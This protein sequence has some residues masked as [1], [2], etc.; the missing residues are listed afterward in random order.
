M[1]T[2]NLISVDFTDEIFQQASNK[3][4]ELSD[5]LPFLLSLTDDQRQGGLKLGD[6]S[7]GFLEKTKDFST[8]NPE[9]IPKYAD[10]AEMLRDATVSSKGLTLARKLNV[11]RLKLEDTATIAGIEAFSA[12][13]M[14]YHAVK[15]AAKQG[16]P[17]AQAIYDDLKKRFPGYNTGNNDESKPTA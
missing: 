17:G 4:D 10:M 3:I 8:Q 5:L 2:T 15:T 16:A 1:K 12:A 13:L 11:L 14:Y 6:K 7:L 9:F